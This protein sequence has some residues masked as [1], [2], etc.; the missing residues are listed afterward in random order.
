[1]RL[2]QCNASVFRVVPFFSLS[3][4]IILFTSVYLVFAT[5]C[6]LV[7]FQPK[8]Q[9]NANTSCSNS[10]KPNNEKKKHISFEDKTRFA[11]RFYLQ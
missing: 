2:T 6:R 5:V 7:M 9:P 4:L 3:A 11:K 10:I 1:M 8:I